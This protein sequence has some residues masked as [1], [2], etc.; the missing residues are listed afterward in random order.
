MRRYGAP[1]LTM[2]PAR[3]ARHETGASAGHTSERGPP[4]ALNNRVA[5][6]LREMVV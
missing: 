6:T 3:L 1:L 5:G 4:R 2:P